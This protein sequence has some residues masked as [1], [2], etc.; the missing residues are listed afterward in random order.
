MR[1]AE[2]GAELPA[3]YDAARRALAEAHRV[4][5]VKEIRDKAVALQAYAQQAKDTELIQHATDIRMRAERRAGELLTEMADRG[6]RD[7][8]EGGDRKSRLQPATVKLAD[9]GIN[10]TQSSRWQALAALEPDKFETRVEQASRHAYDRMTGRF[11]KEAEIAR[12]QA[13]HAK[14]T[15]QGCTVAEL[16]ALIAAG[17]RFP[18]IYGDLA[19]TWDTWAASGKIKTCPDHHYNTC[20]L[21]EAMKLPVAA[22]AAENCALFFWSTGPHVALGNHVPV[23]RA[24]GFEPSTIAFVWVK[25]TP[26]TTLVSL[27]GKGLHWG[28]GYTTRS[29]AEFCFLA[30][31]GSPLRLASDVHQIVLAPVGEH[32]AK[33]EEVRRRIERLYAGPYLELYGRRPAPEWTVWGNEIARTD[34][35][36]YDAADDIN[37]SVAEG[38]RAI[39]E[40]VAAGGPGWGDYPELP[41]FLRRGAP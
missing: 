34:F 24:W 23:I 27:D 36:P 3:K 29:N 13:D 14:R 30:I 4:D 41:D 26:S 7:K 28:N 25:T 33:P 32:S 17:K 19:W 35:P 38:F 15:E 21:D 16:E 9:L 20:S 40:R 31:K 18:V 12:R 39:R 6:E 5:E 8:G 37:K 22:L 11:L 2:N 1:I 10:K